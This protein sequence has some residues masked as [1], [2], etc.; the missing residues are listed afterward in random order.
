MIHQGSKSPI[1]LVLEVRVI[2]Q[3]LVIDAQYYV[4]VLKAFDLAGQDVAMVRFCLGLT[5]QYFEVS[6]I[7]HVQ[8]LG[9]QRIQGR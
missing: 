9:S 6:G 5:Y 8:V 1:Q 7:C 3:G 4:H 2:D